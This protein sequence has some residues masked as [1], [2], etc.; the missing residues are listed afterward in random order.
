MLKHSILI[1]IRGFWR[2]KTQTIINVAGLTISLTASILILSYILYSH[3]VDQGFEHK[4]SIVRVNTHYEEEGTSQLIGLNSFEGAEV[5]ATGFSGIQ[6]V[7]KMRPINS[8]LAKINGTTYPLENTI[9]VDPNFVDFFGYEMVVGDAKTCLQNPNQVV[10]EKNY[11]KKLFGDQNPIGQHI[12]IFGTLEADLEVVGI[13]ADDK[14]SHFNFGLLL[15]FNTNMGNGRSF[16]DWYQ[17][18]VYVY[19]KVPEGTNLSRLENEIAAELPRR[20]PELEEGHETFQLQPLQDIYLGS[21]DVKFTDRFKKGNA[22]YIRILGLVGLILLFISCVNYINISTSKA[23]TRSKEV[24]VKKSVGAG[25]TA[26]MG[27]FLL[28]SVLITGISSMVALLLADVIMPFFALLL[29]VP[30]ELHL[31]GPLGILVFIVPIALFLAVGAGVY[32]AFLLASWNAMDAL[33]NHSR[34]QGGGATLRKVLMTVQFVMT[35]TMI[36]ASIVIYQQLQYTNNKNLGFDKKNLMVVP[37]S[38]SNNVS[39]NETTFRHKVE[40]ISGVIAT[41]VSTDIIGEGYTNNSGITRIEGSDLEVMSTLFFV[42]HEYISTYEVE[43]VRGRDFS[44]ELASDSNAVLVNEAFVKYFYNQEVIGKRL[45]MGSFIKGVPIIGVVKD[46][47]FKGLHDA[48]TPTIF[49]VAGWNKWNLT[50]RHQPGKE[51][52]VK[53][54]VAKLWNELDQDVP[55]DFETVESLY[56]KFY[57]QDRQLSFAISIFSFLCVFISGFGLY[58]MINHLLDKK[59]KEIGVR[60]VLGASI[61]NI[62]ILINRNFLG[63]LVLAILISVPITYVVMEYWLGLFA[64][65]VSI[66]AWPF[67]IAGAISLLLLWCTVMAQTIKTERIHPAEILKGE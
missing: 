34:A 6:S 38:A 37:L 28:E 36:T 3:S 32:P 41:S 56:D 49:M 63:L 21:A 42:D 17:Y 67:V 11:A 8:M 62:L 53:M 12:Q 23:V 14:L 33:K 39:K 25:R 31:T 45:E 22:E 4:D 19:A 16:K 10:I 15:P 24:G 65:R 47:H 5:V 52:E 2:S 26:L 57:A 40:Q 54:A 27:Q 7:V 43:V 58:G 29:D 59:Q 55:F 9:L 66:E 51:K 60:R 50:I 18:S 20:I 64:Y 48:V 44:R 1:S 46:F 30:L 61:G 35:L 13:V